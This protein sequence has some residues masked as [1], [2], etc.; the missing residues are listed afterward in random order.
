MSL[1]SRVIHTFQTWRRR[2]GPKVTPRATV[3]LEQL[4]HRRLLSVNFTGNVPI[5]FPVTQTPG[6]V[7]LPNNP[8]VVHP[9]IAPD[10]QPFIFNSGFDVD[11]IAVSYSAADDTLSIGLNGP[12]AS[13]TSPFS[14]IAGDADDNGNSG[15]VNPEVLAVEPSFMNLPFFG[16]S[17]F[18]GAFLDLNGSGFAQVVAGFS[19]TDP[20][21]PKQYQVAEAVVN[22]S[23]P[24]STPLFGTELPQFEGNVYTVN[25][26]VNPSLE[27]SITHFSQLYQQETGKTLTPSSVISVGAFGGSANTPGVTKMFFP[28]QSFVLSA[29]TQPPLNPPPSPPIL[30]NPHEHR[31]IDTKHR[32][33]VRVSIFGT[34]GFPVSQI[35]P[36]TVELEGVHA[37]AHITR[38][39]KR[40]EFPFQTYVFVADQLNLPSGLTTATLTG[41][42]NSG[43]SFSTQKDVLNIPDSARI[44]GR[45]KQFM[46]NASY[47]KALSKI[48]AKN[49]SAA[50][51]VSNTPVTL[52]SLNPAPHG[53][54]KVKVNYTPTLSAVGRTADLEVQKAKV[55]PKISIDRTERQD[56][57]VKIPTRLKHSMGDYLS[58]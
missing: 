16:G 40:D 25:S 21:S 41:Q 9:I 38:K 56:E 19:G 28:E 30:I 20:R 53:I 22:T 3:R 24:P 2:K 58:S 1:Y 52:A 15:T 11:D 55:R 14:V 49:P 27:F 57:K 48:E 33:L 4:D 18:E 54:A 12:P 50:I 45:L 35:N 44:F 37:I 13:A 8:S 42:T 39:I 36:A 51:S 17:Q 29:A 47:Y 31:I 23:L 26:P 6:V 43:V 5:D 46:G 34:S 32:D 7:V 10:L